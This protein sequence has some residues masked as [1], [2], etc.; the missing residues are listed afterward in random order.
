M[1]YDGKTFIKLVIKL[2]VFNCNS[3]MYVDAFNL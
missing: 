2:Y 1:L 3:D